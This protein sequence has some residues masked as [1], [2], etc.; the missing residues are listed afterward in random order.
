MRIAVAGLGYVGL[1]LACLLSDKNNVI[2]V[3]VIES[4]VKMLNNGISPISDEQIEQYLSGDVHS[5]LA[6]TKAGEAYSSAE[7]IFIATPTNYDDETHSFD[8]STIEDVL[9]TID[10]VNKDATVVI[11]STVPVGYTRSISEKYPDL[12]LL[13][14]PEF[15]R[16]GHAL[17]D[18]LHPS[19]II[20]GYVNES[21]RPQAENIAELL[22]RGSLDADVPIRIIGSTE[23][24]AVKLFSNTYLALRVSFF[25][26]LD[27]YAEAKGLNTREIVD[28]VCLDPR[29]CSFYNNPSFGYGGYCLPKDSK[30]LLSN[31]E[32]V[33]QNLIRAIVDSNKTRKRF[34]ADRIIKLSPKT[35]G[36]Y[37][38]IMKSGSD[39]F[40]QSAMFDIIKYIQSAGIEVILYEPMSSSVALDCKLYDDLDSFKADADVILANRWSEELR[41][42]RDKVYTRDLYQRD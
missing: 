25:N 24:E 15:L 16:E 7:V 17:E 19:R 35:V 5:L 11:K 36:V 20:V 28:G 40:R 34:I 39:N 41:D 23:A 6:T 14:S 37:R 33:P 32:N 2:A 29:I 27:T 22:L 9:S 38:L 3:D 4:K 21:E 1:S 30:Q 31:Y 26:E 18:N 42:V 10:T 13:F 8:T 12:T